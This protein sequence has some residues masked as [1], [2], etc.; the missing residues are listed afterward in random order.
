[1]KKNLVLFSLLFIL[2][3][4]A[5]D[6]F[7]GITTSKGLELSILYEPLRISKFEQQI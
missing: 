1:M 6:H 2:P 7:S 4:L 5:Q 3:V